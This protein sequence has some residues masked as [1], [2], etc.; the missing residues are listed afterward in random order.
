MA[1]GSGKRSS[2][3]LGT[4]SMLLLGIVRGKE[5]PVLKLNRA[6]AQGGEEEWEAGYRGEGGRHFLQNGKES[7]MSLTWPVGP[8]LRLVHQQ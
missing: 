1:Q 3:F 6:L 7:S 8:V 4:S 5:Q 2:I